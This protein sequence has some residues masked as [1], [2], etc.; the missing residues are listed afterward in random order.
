MLRQGPAGAA[1]DYSPTL[2]E[3]AQT[4][5]AVRERL[6]GIEAKPGLGLTTVGLDQQIEAAGQRAGTRAGTA[7]A[8]ALE[9]MVDRTATRRDQR[10]WVAVAGRRA[11]GGGAVVCAA[12]GTAWGGWQLARGVAD[13]RQFLA[14]R[15]GADAGGGNPS[16]FNRLVQL[17]QAGAGAPVARCI[18]GIS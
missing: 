3:M 17:S 16:G 11:A 7:L 9:E 10:W 12:R 5:A 18:A 2:G 15:A 6:A 13:R 4:L 1:V 8:A 14:G